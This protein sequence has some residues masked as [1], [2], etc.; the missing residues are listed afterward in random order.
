MVVMAP[1]GAPHAVSRSEL[2]LL[3][4]AQFPFDEQDAAEVDVD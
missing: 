2:P 3:T 4:A 1:R